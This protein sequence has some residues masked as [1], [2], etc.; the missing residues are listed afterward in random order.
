MPGKLIIA[1]RGASAYAKDNSLD[2]FD[3]AI[4][5]GADMIE[6][7]VRQSRDGVLVAH[8]DATLHLRHINSRTCD[9]IKAIDADIPTV[10][11]VFKLTQGKIKLDI[12]LKEAG[13]EK[14]V[15]NLALQYFSPNDFI[16]TSFNGDCISAVKR[17]HPRIRTG[18]ILGRHQIAKAI[19]ARLSTRCPIKWTR[20]TGADYLVLDYKLAGDRLFKAAKDNGLQV[21]VWTVNERATIERFLSHDD[22]YGIITNYP[23]VA[24]ELREA[25]E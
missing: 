9:E 7:D 24:M 13:Y 10:E 18:L 19:L 6:F 4:Q 22:I 15:V 8:H 11:D 3:K 12:V 25:K 20:K 14:E 16:M 2:S 21:M 17:Y 1:H 23:D 5:M